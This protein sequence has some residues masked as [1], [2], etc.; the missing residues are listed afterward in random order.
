MSDFCMNIRKDQNGTLGSNLEN[1]DKGDTAA[2]EYRLYNG[3]WGRSA[4]VYHGVNFTATGPAHPD[5]AMLDC[6]GTGGFTY[7]ITNPSAKF[8]W[9]HASTG[10]VGEMDGARWYFQK[11]VHFKPGSAVTPT[12]NG[13]VTFEL[14]NNT[15]LTIKARGTDGVLRSAIVALT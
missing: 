15:T 6:G 8:Y 4:F 14:T 11:P 3:G 12:N 13:D 1:W 9:W 5:G 2:I 10:A 7:A